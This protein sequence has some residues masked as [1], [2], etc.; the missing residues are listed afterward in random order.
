MSEDSPSVIN[1]ADRKHQIR[2]PSSKRKVVCPG[3]GEEFDLYAEDKFHVA[4]HE[5][6]KIEASDRVTVLTQA[7][8]DIYAMNGEDEH[9]ANLI[10]ELELDQ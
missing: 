5:G 3:C 4:V 8:L 2:L 7:L 1:L 6:L 10:Q 9:I